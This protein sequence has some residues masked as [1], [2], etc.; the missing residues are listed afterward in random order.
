METSALYQT[1]RST[2]RIRDGFDA[3]D[4]LK[5]ESAVYGTHRYENWRRQRG[6]GHPNVTQLKSML[7]EERA[8]NG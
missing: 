5:I 6:T 1:K 8:G 7:A 2:L 4:T 3:F